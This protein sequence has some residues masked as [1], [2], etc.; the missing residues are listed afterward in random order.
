MGTDLSALLYA[1]SIVV[2]LFLPCLNHRLLDGFLLISFASPIRACTSKVGMLTLGSASGELACATP[3]CVKT[4]VNIRAHCTL[5]MAMQTWHNGKK[6]K[7][8][9]AES[10]TQYA[11]CLE[12]STHEGWP[13][14]CRESQFKLDGCLKEKLDLDRPPYGYFG[15]IRVHETDRP[16]PEDQ[17]PS[18]LDDPRGQGRR[19]DVLPDDFPR[20]DKYLGPRFKFIN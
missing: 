9:C 20:T 7:A 13:E 5:V 8:T 15:L 10:F 11:M 6:V 12:Q 16:K 3:T 2:S 14:P 18:W 4:H 17:R 19:A 1:S